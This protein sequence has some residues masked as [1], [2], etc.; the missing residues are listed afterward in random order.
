M[1]DEQSAICEFGHH[2]PFSEGVYKILHPDFEQK[3]TP[4]LNAFSDYRKPYTDKIEVE[5]LRELPFSYTFDKNT[6]EARKKDIRIFNKLIANENKSLNIL[7]IGA[8]NGWFT[9]QLVKMSHKVVAVDLFVDEKDGLGANKYYDEDWIS[10]Q[11]NLNELDLL[12]GSFDVIILNRCLPY[13]ESIEQ[14]LRLLKSN[15]SDSGILFITGINRV[16][17]PISIIENLKRS[18]LEFENR[19]HVNF[20]MTS[21]AGYLKPADFEALK[22]EGVQ[23]HPYAP[24]HPMSYKGYFFGKKSISYFGIY[25][26][27]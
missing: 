2:F 15:L 23:I 10:I 8:W 5:K 9:H 20:N 21:F 17:N 11:L 7:D 24:Y 25:K 4:F 14:T 16:R 6:W 12:E 3:I 22:K 27:G 1:L 19:Y 18:E 26:A 13:F